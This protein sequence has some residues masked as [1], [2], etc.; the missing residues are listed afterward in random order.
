MALFIWLIIRLIQLF[1]FSRNSIFLS[2]KISQQCFSVGS[3]TAP[4]HVPAFDVMGIFFLHSV[5]F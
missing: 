4:M 2:Q 1:F 5:K 3:R